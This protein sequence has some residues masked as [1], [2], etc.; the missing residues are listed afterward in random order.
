MAVVDYIEGD[1]DTPPP[2]LRFI[3]RVNRW[4]NPT[5]GGWYDWPAG[6]LRKA[7][8]ADSVYRC[9]SAYKSAAGNTTTW[10]TRNPAAFELVGELLAQR[11]KR[12]QAGA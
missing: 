1:N 3:L 7:S 12:L 4:G 10:A 8:Y 6:M 11:M 2:E 5:G 9:Y